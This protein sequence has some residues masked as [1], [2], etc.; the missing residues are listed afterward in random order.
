MKLSIITINYNNR[1]GLSRTIDSIIRQTCKEFEWIVIDGDSTDGSIE[2]IRQNEQHIS[3]WI[4][5][6]DKG[7]YNA[8]NKGLQQAHGEYCLFLNSGDWLAKNNSLDEVLPLLSGDIYVARSLYYNGREIKGK[9]RQLAQNT[10]SASTIA[11]ESLPHQS[12]FIKTSLLC[13]AGG[14]DETYRLLADWAFFLQSALSGTTEFV[15]TD[16]CTTIYDTRGLSATKRTLFEEEKKRVMAI[17]PAIYRK[18]IP[19]A[20]SLQ[21]VQASKFGCICYRILYR[22]TTLFKRHTK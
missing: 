12:T 18:D 6:P 8:M 19:L 16:I 14:Y 17:I 22:M 15:F 5:E 11:R 20:L 10:F 1:D 4:S 9:S 2:L 21:D 13:N 3:Y 7:I